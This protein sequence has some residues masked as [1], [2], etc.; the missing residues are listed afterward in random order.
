M[1]P[2]PSAEQAGDERQLLEERIRM[3][4]YQRYVERGCEPGFDLDDWLQ[5]E[6]EILALQDQRSDLES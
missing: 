4:A 2:H 3:R 1:T 5:A 6:Q